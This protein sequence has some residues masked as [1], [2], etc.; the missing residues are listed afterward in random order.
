MKKKGYWHGPHRVARLKSA[1]VMLVALFVSLFVQQAATATSMTLH[2]GVTQIDSAPVVAMPHGG[3]AQTE[4][5]A[6]APV[7]HSGVRHNAAAPIVAGSSVLRGGVTYADAAA[8]FSLGAVMAREICAATGVPGQV[9]VRPPLNGATGIFSSAYWNIASSPTVV[10]KLSGS[11]SKTIEVL[12]IWCSMYADNGG[13]TTSNYA[14]YLNKR[15]T[16]GSGGTSSSVT[17]VPCDSN[18]SLTCSALTYT[19]NPT[20]GTLV[21]QVASWNGPV[22]YNSARADFVLYEAPAV[23]KPLTLRGT[24]ENLTIDLGGVTIYT[25]GKML[26]NVLVRER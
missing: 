9:E 15:S 4:I 21:G 24:A 5:A 16:A 2:G 19:A 11:S 3:I 14:V 22:N 20:A 18:E 26:V 25:T 13:G 6:I 17:G 7:L 10:F 1:F 12:K 8:G 23:G